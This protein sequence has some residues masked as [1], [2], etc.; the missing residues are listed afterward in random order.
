VPLVLHHG[1]TMFRAPVEFAELVVTIPG[2]EGFVPKFRCLLIDLMSVSP[3]ELP[4]SDGRLHAILSIM[5]AVFNEEIGRTLHDAA[6]RLAAIM[7]RPE[8]RDT[9]AAI[10]NYVLQSASKMTDE[11]FL[12]AIKPLGDTGGDTM[13]TL[14]DKW[15]EEG[16]EEGRRASIIDTLLDRFGAV[17]ESVS[18]SIR[19]ISDPERLV[20]LTAIAVKCETIGEFAES[21]K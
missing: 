12:A 13:S 8:T 6:V 7:D 19:A 9:L 14:I 3:D 2:M 4:T 21:L 11:D 18:L 17:P 15:K 20:K 10:M 16:R 1:R 5:R